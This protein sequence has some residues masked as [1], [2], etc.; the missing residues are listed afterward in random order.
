MHDE[1]ACYLL[2]LY[3]MKKPLVS[4][5]VLNWNGKRFVDPFMKGFLKQ[6]YPAEQLELLFTDNGSTDGSVAYFKERYGKDKRCKVILN[7]GNYGYA[8][9]NDLGIKHITGDYALVC[10]NDLELEASAITE[11]VKAA[12]IHQA[13]VTTAKLMYL[14]KPGIINNA[15]SRLE[16]DS[17]WPIYEL[18]INEEDSDEYRK[19]YEITAFCG[20]CILIKR[21]FL[22]TVGL[23]DKRF[24]LY[25]EDGDLSWRGQKAGKK[26]FYAS[27]AI[28]YHY[29]TGSSTEGSALF[30]HFVGRNRLLILTKNARYRVI[31][32]G[33]A[34]TLRDH[35]LLRVKRILLSLRGKYSKKQALEEFWLSQKMLWAAAF[36]TP[37]ALAKR[38]HIL[39]EDRL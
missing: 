32:K 5:V 27:K 12:Q 24:F 25:F 35:L 31:A 29:H 8:G 14:N 37:Y 39:G 18:G 22:E 21:D 20:A 11:L 13:D 33:W 7:G 10:N 30:N 6:D 38:Y 2:E 28:A 9:G 36:M 23:F 34:K 16:P 17:D 4:V 1:Q 19:D 3:E 15:G 26:Y